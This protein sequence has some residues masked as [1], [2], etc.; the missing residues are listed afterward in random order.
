MGA[1]HARIA[2]SL[3]STGPGIWRFYRGLIACETFHKRRG[4]ARFKFLP[5]PFKTSRN[6]NFLNKFASAF[7]KL[8]II[9]T[10]IL[11]QPARNQALAT[12]KWG[13]KTLK[14]AI[15]RE[16]P[17]ACTDI[18]GARLPVGREPRGRT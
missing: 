5:P 17:A 18:S 10:V 6:F 14:R 4:L 3:T 11:S 15:T 1:R 9:K 16:K 12:E 2:L 13:E 8:N 7:S